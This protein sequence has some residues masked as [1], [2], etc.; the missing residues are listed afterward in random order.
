VASTGASLRRWCLLRPLETL[1]LAIQRLH[2]VRHPRNDTSDWVSTQRVVR[3]LSSR[4]AASPSSRA[5]PRPTTRMIVGPHRRHVSHPLALRQREPSSPVT[6]SPRRA[7]S[8]T[9]LASGPSGAASARISALDPGV[10][11]APGPRPTNE[12]ANEASASQARHSRSRRATGESRRRRGPCSAS[13]A[14]HSPGSCGRSATA[15]LRC[16]AW[17]PYGW[18]KDSHTALSS[19][20]L[21]QKTPPHPRQPPNRV[22]NGFPQLMICPLNESTAHS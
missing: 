6:H 16:W 21:S 7:P 1:G 12:L 4:K 20:E 3:W 15:H 19:F 17:D 8:R 13:E 11:L 2:E 5:C 14:S 18:H 9:S 22:H 10:R